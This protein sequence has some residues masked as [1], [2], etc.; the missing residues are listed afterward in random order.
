MRRSLAISLLALHAAF[1]TEG[2]GLPPYRSRASER[3]PGGRVRRPPSRF[4]A[5]RASA[6]P[7]RPAL[8]AG[9]GEALS[10]RDFGAVGNG[11]VDDTRA[12]Q[13]AL[14]AAGQNGSVVFAP[15]GTYRLDGRHVGACMGRARMRLP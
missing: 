9:S 11:E 14:D 13:A 12:I 5:P 15:P 2:G 6:R 8:Q 7:E 10:I 1:A 3:L 4:A